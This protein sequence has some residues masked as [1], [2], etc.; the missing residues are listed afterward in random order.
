M[1]EVATALG[2]LEEKMGKQLG[3]AAD[4][5]LV[6]VRSG[7]PFSMPGMMDTVLN[8]GLNDVSVGG[9][10]KQTD[11]ARFAF[12]SYRRFVQM[13]AKI[14]LDIDG[15]RFEHALAALREERGVATDP[16]LS[17]EDLEGLVERFKAIVFAEKG[18]EFPQDPTE[19]LRLAIEAVFRSW[20]GERARIYR[21]M[22]KIPDD[23]GTAV[24]VQTMVFGNKGDDSGTGVAF[25]RDPATGENRPYGDFLKN[26]QGE[27][28][29]AGIRVTEHLDAM[30]G[31]FPGPHAELLELMQTLQN[32]Y[33]DM[34]D[35]EF[36]I[37]QG[38]LFLLQTRVGKRT[39]AAAL[40]MAVEMEEEGL[41]DQREAV[42]RVQP[43]QLDQLLHP[44]FDPKAEYHA[45][46][47]GLNASPGAAVGRV[48]FTADA[49]EAHRAAGEDVI[50]VR[51][52]T[53]P[54]DLHG[55]I[56]AEGILTSRGGL[57]SHAAVVARGMGTPAVC[58]ASELDIDVEGGKFQVNGETVLQG[59]VISINGT[60]G[61]VVVGAVPVITP[62]P[63]G[64][65]DVIL[66]WADEFRRLKVRTN[67]DLPHDAEVARRFGAE[68]IGLC[69]TEHMF[70]GDRLPLVQRFILADGPVEEDEALAELEKLQRAD[71]EGIFAAMDGL[72][73]TIRLLD[74]P[75]HE[76][77]PDVEELLVREARGNLEP[78]DRRLLTAAEHWREANPMLGTRGCRLGIIKPGLYRMQTKAILEAALARQQAGGDP[79][80]EIMIPLIVAEPELEL[81]EGWVREV[82]GEVFAAAGAEVD[83]LVG[84]MIETPRAALAA[85]SIAEVAQFFSFGTND[86]TQ[87][88]FGFSRDDVEGRFMAEYLELKLLR[89]NPFETLDQDGVGQLVQL[90]V[91]RGRAARSGIKLGIC[92][93]HGGDP[94]SVE[95]CDRIGLDYV[96]CSP[97][98]VP[99]ARLAAAHAA[100]GAGGP[101]TTA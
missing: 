95:F 41:I 31:E 82:A 61:E 40:R 18:I 33:H 15:E 97:Y 7:A 83:Y 80:V 50:L 79:Q 74:P 90:G 96:S 62:D 89:A 32:H 24:N 76:F 71:F 1:D 13:F 36:T 60:T 49:A 68:G 6:S 98:R 11:N 4:P 91:E 21:R 28:V 35:I 5:L 16:E 81:L 64:P 53:S 47:K 25:T 59:E 23:L 34:C 56:A 46:T 39:A 45:V 78:E 51:P 73:V 67:A 17:A 85:G 70:L 27:D 87:M 58:G 88:T 52:E 20:N 3:D 54:D 30:G 38:R 84:T 12:D 29:V 86:L 92:G 94:A 77:L 2:A 42:L 55:M 57:V 99:I 93:E 8:L 14:V 10:A 75:L 72:P 100:L 19:Q 43:S 48:Y 65:F 101:G 66:G 37:E 69:R 26:A 9:L 63:S 22:E 44:Q